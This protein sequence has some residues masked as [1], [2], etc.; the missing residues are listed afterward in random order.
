[1]PSNSGYLC[2]PV[3]KPEPNLCALSR[4]HC[5]LD[6]VHPIMGLFQK[7]SVVHREKLNI[8][9]F[10]HKKNRNLTAFISF[11]NMHRFS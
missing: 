1:M 7:C 10:E 4:E 8:E 9:F 5:S 6:R 11:E 3:S 2:C